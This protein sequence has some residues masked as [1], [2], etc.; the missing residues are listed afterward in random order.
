M[1]LLDLLILLAVLIFA[2]S[3]YRRGL[4][5]SL[6]VFTLTAAG[7]LL[8]LALL[9]RILDRV[10]D[11]AAVNTTVV[12]TVLIPAT[13]GAAVA[14]R[15]AYWLRGRVLARGPLHTLDGASG[16]LAGAAVLLGMVWIAGNAALSSPHTSTAV[17]DQIRESTTMQALADRLRAQADGWAD[18]ATGALTEACFSDAVTV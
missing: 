14:R 15:P 16:A 12:L 17:Q 5:A 2:V 4:A 6:V 3:G 11:S 18:R 13:L 8:G 1:T 10:G 7:A 9:P